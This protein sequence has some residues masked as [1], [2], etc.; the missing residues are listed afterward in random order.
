[1]LCQE[2]VASHGGKKS[3]TASAK[4]G[5]Q[6]PVGHIGCHLHQGKHATRMGAGAPAHLAAMLECLCSNVCALRFWSLLEMP[7]VVA[8]RATSCL[9]TLCLP[10][11]RMTRNSTRSLAVPLLHVAESSQIFMP[12]CSPRRWA[13][14]CEFLSAHHHELP[15]TFLLVLHHNDCF[16]Q[17]ASMWPRDC[18]WQL[19]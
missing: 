2:R 5:F 4:A 18:G 10:R 6:F 19:P 17:K 1:M 13:S 15:Q 8:R 12:H 16:H 11:P 9:A 7:L 3:T 14:R